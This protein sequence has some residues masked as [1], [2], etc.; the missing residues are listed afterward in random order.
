MLEQ[1]TERTIKKR[2]YRQT[3]G[4]L[5]VVVLGKNSIKNGEEIRKKVKGRKLIKDG[6]QEDDGG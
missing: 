4:K 6:N 5:A 1:R 3:T 2:F